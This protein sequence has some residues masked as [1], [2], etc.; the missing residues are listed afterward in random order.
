MTKT[1]FPRNGSRLCLEIDSSRSYIRH[2][3]SNI[4]KHY[5]R[6]CAYYH[7]L[8]FQPLAGRKL[9]AKNSADCRRSSN[10]IYVRTS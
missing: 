3:E 2:T 10:D 9:E 4:V 8:A 1:V 5:E 6:R 7:K